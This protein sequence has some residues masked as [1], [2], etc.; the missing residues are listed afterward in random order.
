MNLLKKLTLSRL[1]LIVVSIILPSQLLATAEDSNVEK[2]FT[3]FMLLKTQNA[4]LALPPKKRLNFVESKLVP[5][6]EKHPSV[7]MRFYDVE[8]LN[9]QSSDII[10]WETKDLSAYFSVVEQLRET[11]FW[12]HYFNIQAILAGKENAYADYYDND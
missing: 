6:L 11:K 12:G 1:T 5:I 7:Q 8:H 9:A 4:F 3:I 2:P 10:V